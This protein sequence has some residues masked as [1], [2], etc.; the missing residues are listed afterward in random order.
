L[1]FLPAFA[2]ALAAFV[3]AFE[4]D[5]GSVGLPARSER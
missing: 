5:G 2:A 4:V 1:L 3:L